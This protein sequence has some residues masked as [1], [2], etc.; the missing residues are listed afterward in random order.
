MTQTANIR[1]FRGKTPTIHPSAFVDPT[2][3]IIGDVTIGAHASIWPQVVIRGDIHAISI[4]AGTNIQDGSVLHVTHDGPFKPGGAELFIGDQVII[5]H[6]VT[7]HGCTIRSGSLIGMG[8]VILDEAVID[9][10]VMIA[11]GSL[12][13][14]GKHCQSG[15]LWRGNP[16][17]QARK[18]TEKEQAF[19]SYSA[20]YYQRLAAEHK[21]L[22]AVYSERKDEDA[23]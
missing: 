8:A 13:G 11:A 12:V 7:L 18:L 23:A 21:N 3:V 20:E 10:Q 9:S 6:N 4:G 17:R 1:A 19:F 16:A 15:Y 14:P 2:A 22:S 5:G